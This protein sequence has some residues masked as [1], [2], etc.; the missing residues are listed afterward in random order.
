MWSNECASGR[1]R[2]RDQNRARVKIARSAIDPS[3]AI[4]PFPSRVEMLARVID[5]R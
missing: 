4:A 2:A 3:S 1:S 5:T